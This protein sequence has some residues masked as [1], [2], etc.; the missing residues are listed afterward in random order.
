MVIKTVMNT[1]SYH[2]FISL[3][4]DNTF[5]VAI[6]LIASPLWYLISDFRGIV[7][8]GIRYEIFRFL[9]NSFKTRKKI[10]NLDYNIIF[11]ES[12]IVMDT[13][14]I[15]SSVPQAIYL[16]SHAPAGIWLSFSPQLTETAHPGGY[17]QTSDRF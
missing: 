10:S 15:T 14:F 7:C 5:L 4:I 3:K 2:P 6:S 1:F 17:Y 11:T 16:L 13:L 9:F 8:L 12:S